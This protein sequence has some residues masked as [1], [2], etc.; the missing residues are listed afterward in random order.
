MRS[1]LLTVVLAMTGLWANAQSLT[2]PPQEADSFRAAPTRGPA[3]VAPEKPVPL[4]LEV[5]DATEAA[6][7]C[8]A[9]TRPPAASA[10]L[11][12]IPMDKI[13]Q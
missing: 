3:S 1:S 13:G 10:T 12:K 8:Y 5:D 2:A 11:S 9:T 4:A 7:C 6:F